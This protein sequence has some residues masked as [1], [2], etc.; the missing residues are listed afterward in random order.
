MVVR[1]MPGFTNYTEVKK[2]GSKSEYIGYSTNTKPS[3]LRVDQAGSTF[4]ELNTGKKWIWDGTYWVE[5][6]SLIW[7]L[8]E[9]LKG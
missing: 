3:T 2:V 7:A 6:L 5:D 9:V 4:Y 8:N 1:P